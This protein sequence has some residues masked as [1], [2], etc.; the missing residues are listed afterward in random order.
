MREQRPTTKSIAFDESVERITAVAAARHGCRLASERRDF[1]KA[2]QRRFGFCLDDEVISSMALVGLHC[3]RN[4]IL[5][6]ELRRSI[7]DAAGAA[8]EP[9]IVGCWGLLLLRAGKAVP[10]TRP[11]P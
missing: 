8:G 6:S 4:R 2:G 1:F 3:T 7:C 9:A 10:A 11:P 5:H